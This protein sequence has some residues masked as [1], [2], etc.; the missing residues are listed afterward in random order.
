MGSEYSGSG[1]VDVRH[2]IGS[3]CTGMTTTG[4]I[5]EVGAMMDSKDVPMFGRMNGDMKI[6]SSP[7]VREKVDKSKE[8]RNKSTFAPKINYRR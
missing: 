1:F 6:Y 2:V 4:R 3:R 5:A 7:V 8:K